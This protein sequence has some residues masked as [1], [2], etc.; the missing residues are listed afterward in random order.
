MINTSRQPTAFF[1]LKANGIFVLLFFSITSDPMW[2]KRGSVMREWMGSKAERM[3]GEIP[4][5]ARNQSLL[6]FHPP[7]YIH[8]I[9]SF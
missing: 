7:L 1:F 3:F 8:S 9:H 2:K 5:D 4:N 6:N